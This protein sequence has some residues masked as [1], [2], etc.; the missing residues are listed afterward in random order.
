[1]YP[2]SVISQPGQQGCLA[3]SREGRLESE[4][5]AGSGQRVDPAQHEPSRLDG[6]A[7]RVEGREAGGDQVGVDELFAVRIVREEQTGEGALA[8]PVRTRDDI[9]V[10]WACLSHWRP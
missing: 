5:D 10:R 7:L 3:A 4:V 1:M 9:D 6:Q 8:G 2:I